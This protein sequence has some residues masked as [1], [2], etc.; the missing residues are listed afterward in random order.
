MKVLFFNARVVVIPQTKQR[1]VTVGDYQTLKNGVLEIR[2][3]DLKD[4]RYSFLIGIHE[5]IEALLCR[6]AGISDQVID[7]FDFAFSANRPADSGAEPGDDS[8]APYHKQHMFA[9]KVERLAGFLLCVNWNK[10]NE[11][12]TKEMSLHKNMLQ[13]TEL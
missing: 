4:W 5:L 9:K 11:A 13:Q 1:Y 10:Y 7:D 6:R 8:A 2:V 3:S 12:C